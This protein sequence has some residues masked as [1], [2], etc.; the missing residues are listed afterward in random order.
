MAVRVAERILR[1]WA[2]PLRF[3]VLLLRRAELCQA[4]TLGSKAT[5]GVGHFS[6]CL[7]G[8]TASGA[9]LLALVERWRVFTP[10]GGG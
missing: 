9:Y 10:L 4:F 8:T 6:V 5:R 7:L 2:A 1:V 3:L